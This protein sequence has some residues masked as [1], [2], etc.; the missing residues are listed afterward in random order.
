MLIVFWGKVDYFYQTTTPDPEYCWN[1]CTGLHKHQLY[2]VSWLKA[3]NV[4]QFVNSVIAE[5]Q[6]NRLHFQLLVIKWIWTRCFI[7]LIIYTVFFYKDMSPESFIFA[8]LLSATIWSLNLP[9]KT[10][11]FGQ[12]FFSLWNFQ[13]STKP[14]ADWI[15]G[16]LEKWYAISSLEY[17]ALQRVCYSN[18]RDESVSLL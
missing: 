5:K 2:F 6:M 1:N 8:I 7:K 13:F 10:K 15:Y 11:G 12:D 18:I 14:H 16:W 3:V 4:F 17:R 9:W